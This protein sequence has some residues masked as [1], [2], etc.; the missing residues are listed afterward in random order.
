MIFSCDDN[1][2][3]AYRFKLLLI[4]VALRELPDLSTLATGG[5]L[6]IISPPLLT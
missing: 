4:L 1:D 5:L 2:D 3:G 6:R